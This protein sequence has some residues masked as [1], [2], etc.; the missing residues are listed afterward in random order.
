M[1]PSGLVADFCAR[2]VDSSFAGFSSTK[3]RS[4]TRTS[5]FTPLASQYLQ[6]R[7]TWLLTSK[8][9]FPKTATIAPLSC[10][11]THPASSWKERT[12]KRI[13]AWKST[14]LPPRSMSKASFILFWPDLLCSNFP[15]CERQTFG[16]IRLMDTQSSS[17]CSTSKAANSTQETT[18]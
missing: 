4:G 17:L 11:P 10:W 16:R 15:K 8:W 5:V 7:T 1:H 3:L 14:V 2:N 12:R 18:Q 6:H 9:T 13:S